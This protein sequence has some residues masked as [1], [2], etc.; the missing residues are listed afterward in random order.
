MTESVHGP[1]K[2]TPGF[3]DTFHL[4]PMHGILADFHRQMLWVLLFLTVMLQARE[5]GIGLRILAVQ[6]GPLQP[7]YPSRFSTAT[8]LQPLLPV[9]RGLFLYIFSYNTSVHL[10]FGWFSKS[11]ILYFSCNFNAVIGGSK[12]SIHQLHYLYQNSLKINFIYLF[13]VSV[14]AFLN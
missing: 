2:R 9:S 4:T 5:P 3:L 13:Y 11:F 6:S 7:T 8:C 1:F 14:T 12:H 10:V